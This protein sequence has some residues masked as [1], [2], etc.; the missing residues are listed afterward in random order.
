MRILESMNGANGQDMRGSL[1]EVAELVL[2]IEGAESLPIRCSIDHFDD[3]DINRQRVSAVLSIYNPGLL[4]SRMTDIEQLGYGVDS[5][6]TSDL[7]D[8]DPVFAELWAQMH[9]GERLIVILEHAATD[10]LALGNYAVRGPGQWLV[11]AIWEATGVTPVNPGYSE[12]EMFMLAWESDQH[13]AAP[14]D[15]DQ[16]FDFVPIGV[17]IARVATGAEVFRALLWPVPRSIR[18]GVLPTLIGGTTLLAALALWSL[19][20]GSFWALAIY[21]LI[22]T[23]LAVLALA[24]I[25]AF[26]HSRH[27]QQ[28]LIS[29]DDDAI[30]GVKIVRGMTRYVEIHTHYST[31]VGSGAG[32]RFRAALM[33]YIKEFVTVIEPGMPI[34]VNCP[35]ALWSKLEDQIKCDFPVSEGWL[36]ARTGTV[37][38]IYAPCAHASVR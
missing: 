3:Y 38:M 20:I 32:Y 22:T 8:G 36:I 1:S 13:V 21:A 4:R 9:Q 17:G 16:P 6:T 30:I 25:S 19:G 7:Q 12:N 28:V 11:E 18:T 31:H 24:A 35:D 26:C 5:T 29:A 15:P 23:V 10:S 14:K 34:R 33:P 27:S 37:V 2:A